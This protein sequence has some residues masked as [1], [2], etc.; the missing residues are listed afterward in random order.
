M[1][2]TQAL[3]F[4]NT[5]SKLLETGTHMGLTVSHARKIQLQSEA[6]DLVELL[7]T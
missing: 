3:V 7:I 4:S 1:G 6:F 5:D 2:L